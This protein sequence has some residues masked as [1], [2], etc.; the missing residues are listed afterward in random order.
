M[1]KCEKEYGSEIIWNEGGHIMGD[2]FN[3]GKR[4]SENST[5]YEG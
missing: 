1:R 5:Q 4:C 3:V 2:K